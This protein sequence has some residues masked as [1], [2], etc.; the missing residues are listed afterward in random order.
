[1]PAA[2]PVATARVLVP[3][4]AESSSAGKPRRVRLAKAL[5]ATAAAQ[6]PGLA[7]RPKGR[8]AKKSKPGSNRYKLPDHEFAQLTALKQ[9][10]ETLGIGVRRSEL[11][12]A[13]LMLLVAM[14]DAQLQKAVAAVGR[15]ESAD[16]E[17]AA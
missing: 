13:G 1:M 10:M 4:A 5:A 15:I 9:R 6:T 2:V 7:V 17:A 12:R 14:N 8:K 3:A 16:L 11:L